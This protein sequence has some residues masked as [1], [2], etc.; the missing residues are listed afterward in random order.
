M[1]SLY[2][3]HCREELKNRVSSLKADMQPLFGKMT[4][5]TAVP[6]LIDQLL[7]AE[8]KKESRERN[9]G[10]IMKH[11]MRPLIIHWLPWPKGKVET[12]PEMLET[13]AGDF[14]QDKQKLKSLIDDFPKEVVAG[15]R[16]VHPAFGPLCGREWAI[17]SYR[18]LD[19]HLSQFGV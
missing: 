4:A 17:L 15:S 6:H 9:T 12:V 13:Q 14:E 2:N 10:F 18:H 1:K 16:R 11:I 3:S 8:G 19:H 7:V 5:P